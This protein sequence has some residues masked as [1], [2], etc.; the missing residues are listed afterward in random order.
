[1]T[2]GHPVL[3]FALLGIAVTILSVYRHN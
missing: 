2:S 3:E 1:M